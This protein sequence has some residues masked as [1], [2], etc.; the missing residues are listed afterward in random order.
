MY[1]L[2][3]AAALFSSNQLHGHVD[4]ADDENSF[5]YLH[6]ARDILDKITIARINVTRFQRASEGA[7]HSANGCGD[8]VVDSGGMGLLQFGRIDLVMLGNR[9]VHAEHHRLGFTR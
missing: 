4:A 7:E 6:L 3:A 2:D 9:T 8:H 5:P 1:A